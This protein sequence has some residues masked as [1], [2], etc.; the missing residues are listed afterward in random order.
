MRGGG[1]GLM[2]MRIGG[3]VR[4]RRKMYGQEKRCME[5]GARSEEKGGKREEEFPPHRTYK[6][7][8]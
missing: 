7:G 3:K 5:R 6:L 1:G 4:G 2:G 8:S